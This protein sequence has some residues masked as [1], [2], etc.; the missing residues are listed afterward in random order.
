MVFSRKFITAQIVFLC[1]AVLLGFW[2]AKKGRAAHL[3]VLGTVGGFQL[4]NQD[5]QNTTL[6]DLKGRIWVADF[7]FTTCSGLCPTMSK[8]MAELQ[9]SFS[10]L[11]DVRFVSISV[12]PE[13]DTPEVLKRYADKYQATS[14]QWIFLTG[15]QGDIQKLA[16]ESFKMG[17]MKD[18]LFHSSFFVLVDGAGRVRGYYEGTDEVRLKQLYEDL[19]LLRKE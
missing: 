4:K 3:P 13:T 7:I 16:L 6:E 19:S 17:D 11:D 18:I 15:P 12:N 1:L 9:K 10:G 2:Y 14:G 8:H 5:N